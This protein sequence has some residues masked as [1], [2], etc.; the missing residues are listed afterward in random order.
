[1]QRIREML[2]Y[3][4]VSKR[5]NNT[6]KKFIDVLKKATCGNEELLKRDIIVVRLCTDI[7]RL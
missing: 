5:A 1:M 3:F 4:G 2:R 6:T 7:N